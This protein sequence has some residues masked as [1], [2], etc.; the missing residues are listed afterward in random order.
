LTVLPVVKV[1]DGAT[2]Q[3]HDPGVRALSDMVARR[4]PVDRIFGD[5]GELLARVVQ[6]SGG[7]LRM[8]IA[9]VREL[10]IRARRRGLP[11]TEGDIDAVNAQLAEKARLAVRPEGIA[12]LDSI[13]RHGNL[14]GMK[15]ADL[16]QLARY[17]DTQIVLCYRNGEGWYELHPLVHNY[18]ARRA[19]ELQAEHADDV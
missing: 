8:L 10:L 1:L 4:V 15:H 17:M 9:F 12:L 16:P 14:D 2:R 18:V 3:P 13:R 7:H 5:G 6:L 19:A 11:T